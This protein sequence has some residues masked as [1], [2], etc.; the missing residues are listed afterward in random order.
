MVDGFG[1]RIEYLRISVTD[2]CNLRCVYCM[3]EEGLPWLRRG[4]ILTYEEIAEIVSVM[5]DMGLRRLRLTGGEPLVRKDLSRLVDLLAAVPG[6]EDIAL[7]T[8]AVLLAPVAKRLRDAG[9][10]RV[11]ISLDSLRPDRADAIARRPG[12]LARIMDGLDAAH[13]VGFDP[14]KINVV[15][16]RGENDDE[17]PDFAEL[18][19]DRPLHVRFIEVMPTESN[20]ELSASNFL[21]CDEALARVSEVDD[22]EPVPGPPGNGPAT[23]FSFPG[24]Q[25]T[26]G[27]ITPM[28]HNF[29]SRCNRM[30]L[31]ADGQLRPCL[32]GTIQT[33]LRDALRRGEALEPLINETLRIKPEKHLLVQGSAEGSGGLIALSQT[34]G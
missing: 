13:A 26:I 8:N 22:L 31:T 12:T 23:Y 30:R 9:V 5:A 33:P 32:F 34:G 25:G 21:S 28:S 29:C 6:I 16:M 11:N 15:L 24:A 10:S 2:K 14:I 3:P 1:R 27:V 19:R 18:S 17:I 4:E 20:L 7:S